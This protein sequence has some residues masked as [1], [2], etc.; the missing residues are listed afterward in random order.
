MERQP[1]LDDPDFWRTATVPHVSPARLSTATWRKSSYSN[2]EG[3][4]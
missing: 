2:Q 4:E 3:G 1:R